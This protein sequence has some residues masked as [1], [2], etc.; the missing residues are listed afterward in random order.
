[1]QDT[2]FAGPDG[3]GSTISI[4]VAAG[5]RGGDVRSWGSVPN[6]ADQIAK[7]VAKHEAQ[8]R[9]LRLC[10]EAGACG[11]GLQRPLTGLGPACDGVAPSPIPVRAG[12]RAK[13][14]RRDAAM[15]AERVS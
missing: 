8:G 6:R 7:L 15:L 10:H 3:H 12:D 5:E 11:Y 2:I 13:T 14:V 4:A 1:M 9:P